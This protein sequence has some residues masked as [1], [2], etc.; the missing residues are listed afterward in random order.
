MLMLRKLTE[1]AWILY[2]K[3]LDIERISILSIKQ[4]ER[5]YRLTD[6]TYQ[7][8][9]RRRNALEFQIIDKLN[10]LPKNK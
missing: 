2:L 3:V 5:I 8:Y 7:R 10:G 1:E 6:Q 4:E 9:L